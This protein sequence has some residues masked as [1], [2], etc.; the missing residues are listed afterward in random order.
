MDEQQIRPQVCCLEPG[1]NVEHPSMK[2][3]IALVSIASW[4]GFL[5]TDLTYVLSISKGFMVY[6]SK[7]QNGFCN[8]SM[9]ADPS[10]QLR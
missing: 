4:D 9:I 10:W 7:F 1:F 6:L 3:N 5:F 2:E 8:I